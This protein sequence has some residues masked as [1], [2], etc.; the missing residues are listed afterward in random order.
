M[1]ISPFDC[2]KDVTTEKKGII[3]KENNSDYVPFI[4][5]LNLSMAVDTVAFANE[6]NQRHQMPGFAQ[7][8]FYLHAIPKKRRFIKW[9]KDVKNE[10]IDAIQY[11]FECNTLKAHDLLRLL[12]DEEMLQI[13]QDYKVYQNGGILKNGR[14]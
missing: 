2:V 6:M 3:S 7:Y 11:V 10:D 8:A 13:R 1:S 4:V 9:V 5:N 14:K 12:N